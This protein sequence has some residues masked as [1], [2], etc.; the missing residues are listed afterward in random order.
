[1]DRVGKEKGA[2]LWLRAVKVGFVEKEEELKQDAEGWE[3]LTGQSAG[4][5]TPE[6]ERGFQINK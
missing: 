2:S 3:G 5:K 4:S 6:A 1:M